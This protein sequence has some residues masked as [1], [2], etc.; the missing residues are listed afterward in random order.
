MNRHQRRA[1]TALSPRDIVNYTLKGANDINVVVGPLCWQPSDGSSARHWYFMIITGEP[2]RGLRIDQ[3]TVE[4]ETD[5]Q[6]VIVEFMQR[7]PLVLHAFDDEL[8]MARWCEAIWPC[9]RITRIRKNI[10]RERRTSATSTS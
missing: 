7:R 9:E 2:S 3:V 8:D 10:E 4:T 1:P 6:R 5:R